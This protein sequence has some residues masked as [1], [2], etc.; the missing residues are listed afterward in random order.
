VIPAQLEYARP[1]T[2]D[3]ALAAL[4]QP[5][6]KALAGGQSLVSVLKLRLVRPSVVVDIGRLD[7]RGIE[8]IEADLRIGAL[9]TWTELAEAP[10]LERPALRGLGECAAGVGDLQVKNRGTIGGSLA[11]ADPASDIPAVLIALGARL[12][13]RSADGERAVPATDFFLGPFL[14][15]LEPHELLTEILVPLPAAGSGSAYEAIEH[16]ASGFALAGASVCVAA[17][18]SRTIGLTGIGATPF[19]L[20]A[21]DDPATGLA[22]A[23]VF[24]DDFASAEYKRHLAGVVVE[25]ALDSAMRHAEEDSAWTA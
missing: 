24:G 6:A 3:E 23:D 18:G 14:T 25:R 21:P 11:H 13:L 15:A 1:A 7:L 12:A 5:D 9:T 20:E 19:P 22:R 4:E 17:D 16:P 2:L 8:T 10:A